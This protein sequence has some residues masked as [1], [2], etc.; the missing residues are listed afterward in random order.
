MKVWAG[1]NFSTVKHESLVY[2]AVVKKGACENFKELNKI[3]LNSKTIKQEL[4]W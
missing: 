4:S 2:Q 1:L 3:L